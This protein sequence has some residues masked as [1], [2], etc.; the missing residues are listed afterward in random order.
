M[1]EKCRKALKAYEEAIASAWKAYDVAREARAPALKALQE[2]E[3][4]CEDKKKGD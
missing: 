4:K 3:A 2:A 1:C